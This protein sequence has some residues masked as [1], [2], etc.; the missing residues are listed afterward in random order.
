MSEESF[1][2]RHSLIIYFALA[3]AIA[4]IGSF[5]LVGPEFLAG[6]VIVFDDIGKMAIVALIA[7]FISGLLT[8]YVADGKAGLKELFAKMKKYKVAGRWYLPLLIFPALLLLVSVLLGILVSPEM[9]PVF[10]AFGLFGGLLAG[11][12]E[13]TGWTGFA[14]PKMS[15]KASVLSTS[16]YLGI[17]H[18]IWHFAFSFLG[19]SNDLG[20]YYFPYFFGSSLHIV[21]L[22][23]LIV[24]VYSNTD[25]VFLAMLMHVSSTGFFGLLISTTMAPVNWL[26]FYTVYG[27]VLCLAASVVALKYGRTLKEK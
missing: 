14:Y 11:V 23:V 17:I 3:Y 27:I 7:P 24:W 19:S 20:G 15:G 10:T 8:T 25:S 6:E 16:I 22:R 12:L 9:A 4:W 26:I 18:A 2:R 21:A 13:E 1:V 5:A